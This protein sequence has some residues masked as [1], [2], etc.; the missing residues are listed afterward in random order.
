MPKPPASGH[1]GVYWKNNQW[2]IT[3]VDSC[4]KQH[5]KP[6]GKG[7]TGAVSAVERKRG[8][9]KLE[10]L[11]PELRE[12]RERGQTLL[13][14]V[15]DRLAPLWA[16]KA[17]AKDD[18]RYAGY[19][20]AELGSRPVAS[21]KPVDLQRYRSR[22]LTEGAAPATV[23]RAVSFLRWVFNQVPDLAPLNPAGG[24]QLGQLAEENEVTSYLWEDEQ[25]KLL[26]TL[27]AENRRKVEFAFLTG[28]RSANQWGMRREWV[29]LAGALATIPTTKSGKPKYIPL[30]P[31][32]VELLREQLASHQSPWVWPGRDGHPYRVTSANQMLKRACERAGIRILT[33]HKLRH[34][35]G[36]R[37]VQR[38]DI[39]TVK[40][41][42]DHSSVTV[43]ER[44]TRTNAT[45]IRALIESGH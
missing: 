35:F 37:A 36:T 5:H 45:R 18:D 10:R 44:Y 20:R 13:A 9:A 14:D 33:W 16:H 12:A 42:M 25:P 26:A 4:G 8:E 7:I 32:L 30:S 22:R 27:T 41:A 31:R 2:Y 40:E 24:R 29:D 15:L 23:N 19:W 17:S 34:T 38:A 21:I 28:L 43:T 6:A 1:K 3:W 11:Q 39:R